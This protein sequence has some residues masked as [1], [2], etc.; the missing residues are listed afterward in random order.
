MYRSLDRTS[1]SITLAFLY[2][3]FEEVPAFNSFFCNSGVNHFNFLNVNNDMLRRDQLTQFLQQPMGLQYLM[4]LKA[5]PNKN[6]QS[7]EMDGIIYAKV[8]RNIHIRLSRL[9][10]ASARA[11]DKQFSLVEPFLIKL[12]PRGFYVTIITFLANLTPFFTLKE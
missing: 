6:V 8:A 3:L 9:Y 1:G 12:I 7:N 2:N 11:C 4:G 10:T 5:P